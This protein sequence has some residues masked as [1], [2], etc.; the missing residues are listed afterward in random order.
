MQKDV[1]IDDIKIIVWEDEEGE[2]WYPLSS[3]SRLFYL[4]DK[5]SVR[6]RNI[7]L[8]HGR[9]EDIEY[10]SDMSNTT[11]KTFVVNKKGLKIWVCKRNIKSMSVEQKINHNKLLRYL[12]LDEIL[13]AD[14]II[15]NINE[16]YIANN[17]T[18][19]EKYMYNLIDNKIKLEFC[20]CNKCEKYYPLYDSFYD[21]STDGFAKSNCIKCKRGEFR[22]ER[23]ENIKNKF[24]K[25]KNIIKKIEIANKNEGFKDE[26]YTRENI[27]ELFTELSNN[28]TIS[29]EN[30][31][32]DLFKYILNKYKLKYQKVIKCIS[33]FDLTII[34]YDI[35]FYCRPYLYLRPLKKDLFTYKVQ[36]QIFDNYLKDNN[37]KINDIL[38]FKYSEIVNKSKCKI[39]NSY[40]NGA[41]D[42]LD[43][44]D[45]YNELKY[46]AYKYKIHSVDY[47]KV[48]E[49]RIRALKFLVEELQLSDINKLPIY[50]TKYTLTK[51]SKTMYG[52]YKRYYTN[53][54][55]WVNEVYPN[56]FEYSDFNTDIKRNEFDSME[57]MAVHE[58]LKDKFGKNLIYN[59]GDRSD[60]FNFC[61]T[62][63]QPDWIVV[64]DKPI[65]IEYFGVYK[66]KDK[67]STRMLSE[68]NEKTNNKIDAYN[69]YDNYDKLYIYPYDLEDSY[70]GLY[71]K[72]KKY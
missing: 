48:K 45:K 47:W 60:R 21:R 35:D 63:H 64:R 25:E 18:E 38:E 32:L 57:E 72:L 17:Y 5:V 55:D 71:D 67:C 13:I 2:E 22:L 65:V 37:I 34:L 66:E 70:S 26:L 41:L 10:K 20:L 16:D 3:I 51:I 7:V 54:F 4:R 39:S 42:C 9:F 12:N 40:K 53:L 36:K 49:N 52:V 11:S 62:T 56:Q 43:F 46:P 30:F 29:Y 23:K 58:I 69:Q 15:K 33:Y 68:Y 27:I 31:S 8:E 50:L 61:L 14:N 19:I 28:G 24:K 1:W 44:V 59:V 6:D